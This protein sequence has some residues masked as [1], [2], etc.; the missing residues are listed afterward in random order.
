MSSTINDR[1]ALTSV[2]FHNFKALREFSFSLR[3]MNILVGPNNSGK[4]TILSAFRVLSAGLRKA[5]SKKP[6]FVHSPD[7][8]Q[9][10]GYRIF[11]DNMPISIENIHTDDTEVD[12]TIRFRLSNKNELLIYFPAD[13][14]CVLIPESTGRGIGGPAAF[15]SSFPIGVGIVPVLGPVEHQERIIGEETVRRDLYTHRASRHFRSYWYHNP[16]GFSEF[17]ELIRKTWPGMEVSRPARAGGFSDELVMVCEESGI[18]REL[19]WS[20]F[21]FQVWCQLLTHIVRSSSQTL[22]IVDEPE[23]YLHPEIQRQLLNILRRAGPDIVIATHSTEIMSEA[24]PSEILL[25]DKTKKSAPRLRDIGEVQKALELIGSAQN[26]TLTQLAKTRRVIFVEGPTDFVLL[27]RFAIH[28]GFRDLGAGVGLTPVQSEGA[29]T[30]ERISYVAWGIEKTLGSELS[31]GAIFDRDFRCEEEIQS[32]HA[33]LEKR[34]AFTHFHARKEIENYL[35]VPEVLDR[36]LN[37]AIQDRLKRTGENPSAV[38][39]MRPVLLRLTEEIK[40]ETQ[41]QYLAKWTAFHRSSGNDQ[42]TL[43]TEAI[44]WFDERWKHLD[45]RLT[46]VPGKKILRLLRDEVQ[47]CYEVNLTDLRI[48][49]A[50]HV[51]E[52]PGELR[53][54]IEALD[55][56]RLGKA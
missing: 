51:D 40:N 53:S 13:G 33:A 25:V 26:I 24:D 47:K 42:A 39:P 22:L 16:D 3:D 35:L 30:W 37:R 46:I 31:I 15:R 19:F 2:R 5:N 21:G 23:I 18:P 43:T 20:G 8:G 14:G 55:K 11:D 28:L 48:V 6:E 38:E 44:R 9:R 56:Y 10:S 41:G 52:C 36:A 7:G 34:L 32:I 50:F 1:V 29:S 54:L 45:D 4:S 49:D 17:S 27:R 12:T